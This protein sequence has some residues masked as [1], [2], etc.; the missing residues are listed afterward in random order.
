MSSQLKSTLWVRIPVRI[1]VLYI[2]ELME[3][4]ENGEAGSGVNL[5]FGTDILTMSGH[6][7]Y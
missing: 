2:D 7:M 3:Y 1:K 5:Q 6:S 4:R